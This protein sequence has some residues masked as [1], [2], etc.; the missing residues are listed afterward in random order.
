M[1]LK[2]KFKC[3][4]ITLLISILGYVVFYFLHLPI[5]WLL[6][7]LAAVLAANIKLSQPLFWPS[8]LRNVG[9]MVIGYML[10]TSFSLATLTQVV[11]QLP[12]MLLMTILTLGFTAG[13]AYLI[14]RLSSVSYHS[15]LTGS[16]PGGLSQMVA[17]GEEIK[18]I[19]LTVVTF[20]QI[21][22]L[23]SV[24]FIVPFVV[25]YT[26][27]FA[28]GHSAATSAGE[29]TLSL[30]QTPHTFVFIAAMIIATYL[31]KLIRIPTPFLLGPVIAVAALNIS[32]YTAPGLDNW[33]IH[34]AQFVMGA[35]IA[36]MMKPQQLQNKLRT[37]L[38]ALIT[39][40]ALILF[41][42]VASIG[43]A[44]IHAMSPV[45]AFLA[46]APGGMSQMAVVAAEVHADLYV[47]TGYQMF[48]LFFIL[49]LVPPLLKWLFRPKK[50]SQKSV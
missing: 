33:M 11:G 3:W 12:S 34:G 44:Y 36:L 14:S 25:V 13:F 30:F 23:M 24:I 46:M 15:I 6:G 42:Y 47:V 50:E 29:S 26:P 16:I 40:V 18:G 38:Y 20:I 19:D 32:G 37:A 1:T 27:L 31:A 9:L 21:S 43:L 7:P 48:R 17:L 8:G 45:T 39:G 41:A 49:F 4:F 28:E 5:P 22:R 35:Y 2:E 10:G